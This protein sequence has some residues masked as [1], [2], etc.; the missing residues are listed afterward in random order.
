MT[1]YIP[2]NMQSA[3]VL[4]ACKGWYDNPDFAELTTLNVLRRLLAVH[5]GIAVDEVTD[6]HIAYAVHRAVEHYICNIDDL[7]LKTLITGVG[8]GARQ[9]TNVQILDHFIGVLRRMRVRDSEIDLI[10]IPDVDHRLHALMY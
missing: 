10:D 9:S 4:L 6:T 8:L 3:D 1:N 7:D 2:N 5:L